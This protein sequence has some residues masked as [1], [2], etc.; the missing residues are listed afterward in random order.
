MPPDQI[1]IIRHAQKPTRKPKHDGIRE[2]GTPDPE[3]LIVRGWQHACA[4]ASIFFVAGG[5]PI[6]ARMTRPNV[7]FAAGEGKKKQTIGGKK[8]TVGSHSRRPLETVTPMARRLDLTPVITFTKGEEPLLVKDVLTRTGTV[9]ICWQHQDIA[10][11]GNLIVGNDTTVPQT[12]PENRYDLIWVF[13]RVGD[14]WSFRQFFHERLI[15][16]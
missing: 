13:D 9:L 5:G 12:W 4:L 7:I 1:I 15:P 16:S 10:T 3:S 8:V 14:T 11:I 2:D 6:D